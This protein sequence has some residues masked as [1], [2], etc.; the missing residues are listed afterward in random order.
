MHELPCLAILHLANTEKFVQIIKF[1]SFMNFSTRILR[2]SKEENGLNM[3]L[4]S[5][6][7]SS[8]YVINIEISVQIISHRFYINFIETY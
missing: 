2:Q 4:A 5:M 8:M 3:H 7:S 1:W 6:F